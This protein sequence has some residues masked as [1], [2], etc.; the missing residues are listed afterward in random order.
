M[1]AANFYS[2]HF[3]KS[4]KDLIFLPQLS[5]TIREHTENILNSSQKLPNSWTPFDRNAG[6]IYPG[7]NNDLT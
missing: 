1:I 3:H 2:G 6:L 4:E 5:L 7:L